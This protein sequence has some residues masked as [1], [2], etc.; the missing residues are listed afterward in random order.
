[1]AFVT[2]C[3]NGSIVIGSWLKYGLAKVLGL[4]SVANTYYEKLHNIEF[5]FLCSFVHL[6]MHSAN[7]YQA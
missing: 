7:L 6:F 4:C 2:V 3:E 5:L 1:M